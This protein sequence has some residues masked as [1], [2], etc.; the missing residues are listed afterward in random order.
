MTDASR[1]NNVIFG[2]FPGGESIATTAEVVES[3][4]V[5]EDPIR[6]W[7]SQLILAIRTNSEVL[8][9]EQL[10]A[11]KAQPLRDEIKSLQL[12]ANAIAEKLNNAVDP[13]QVLDAVKAFAQKVHT[14]STA[15][16]ALT[17]STSM[18]LAAVPQEQVQTTQKPNRLPLYIGLGVGAVTLIGLFYYAGKKSAVDVEDALPAGTTRS[19]PKKIKLKRIGA[20]KARG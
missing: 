18:A 16:A 7:Y 14:W 6:A 9:N 11:E 5:Q 1:K 17:E 4:P 8:A 13:Q 19:K 10:S 2:K 20:L 12:E 15:V 3:T